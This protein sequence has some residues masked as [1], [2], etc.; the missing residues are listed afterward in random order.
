MPS[1]NT[2]L[3]GERFEIVEPAPPRRVDDVAQDSPN[4]RLRAWDD[5]NLEQRWLSEGVIAI[6][7]DEIG[8]LTTWPGDHEVRRLLEDAFA[9]R[10]AESGTQAYGTFVRYWRYFRLEMQP[11]QLVAVPMSARRVGI[12]EITGDYEYRAMEEDPRM[13][14]VR[15]VRWVRRA[16]RD[17]LDDAIR[18]VVNAPGT[19]CQIKHGD[20]RDMVGSDT[21]K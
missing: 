13:R 21:S 8:D 12:A 9:R 16:S 10:G 6:S 17:D 20:L 2:P 5:P 7:Q 15:S 1:Y 3:G 18:K 4:W 11:G 19:V 14:H